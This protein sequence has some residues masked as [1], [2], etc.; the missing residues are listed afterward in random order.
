MV[1]GGKM[2]KLKYSRAEPL[3]DLKTR[4]IG[5]PQF[6]STK[7][8]FGPHSR[9]ITSAAGTKVAGLFPAN[10][11][12][13]IPS[14]GC[15][16]TRDHSSFDPARKEVAN[17]TLMGQFSERARALVLGWIFSSSLSPHVIS[18]PKETHNRR[19]GCRVVI[20][21]IKPPL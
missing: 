19:N 1:K 20:T 13:K 17:P 21:N 2:S 18:A 14:E 11:T 8:I 16:R 9:A 10:C 7:S 3:P 6:R 12:P 5:H 15:L 4:S